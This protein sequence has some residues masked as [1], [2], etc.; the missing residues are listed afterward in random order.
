MA[1]LTP[2]E[3]EKRK[4][5]R[6]Q[7][8]YNETHKI[9]DGIDHKLYN[10]CNEWFPSTNEYFYVSKTNSIDGLHPNCKQCAIK[11]SMTWIEENIEHYKEYKYYKVRN[12]TKHRKERLREYSR[13]QI[14]KGYTKWYYQQNKERFKKY[15]DK[16]AV[17][18]HI[19]SDNEWINCKTYFD[20]KCAYCG[21]SEVDHK[22]KFG[23][24]LHKEHVIHDGRNDLKN[25]IPSC[26]VCNSSKKDQTLNKWYNKENPNY[27]YERYNL[28]YQW[29]RYDCKKYLEP[30]N[31]T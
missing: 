24:Q 17:K 25:C 1:K 16:R 18:E 15:R 5:E 14:A 23:E 20:F 13:R 27:T 29:L 7:K 11:K 19:I 26:K 6:K 4:L 12:P 28:I 3:K 22:T 31:K 10:I 8:K 30:K 9:I 2:E 21:I